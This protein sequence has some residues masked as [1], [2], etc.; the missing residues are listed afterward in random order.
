MQPI[1]SKKVFF[2]L[3]FFPEKE[4][5]EKGVKLRHTCCKQVVGSIVNI[6]NFVAGFSHLKN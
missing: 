2:R 4:T 5:R 6:C 3:L 1:F